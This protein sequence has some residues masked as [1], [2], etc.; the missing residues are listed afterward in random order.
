MFSPCLSHLSITFLNFP[1]YQDSNVPVVLTKAL[2]KLQVPI[3]HLCLSG[4][5]PLS[6]HLSPSVFLFDPSM[7]VCVCVCVCLIPP[8]LPKCSVLVLLDLFDLHT[9]PHVVA[10]LFSLAHV[11]LPTYPL[12]VVGILPLQWLLFLEGG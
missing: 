8:S 6:Y 9:L 2:S 4:S 1:F 7:W 5:A 11:C 10:I 3:L 12:Q